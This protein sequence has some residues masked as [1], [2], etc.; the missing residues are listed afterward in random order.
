MLLSNSHCILQSLHKHRFLFLKIKR[1]IFDSISL[2]HLF[3]NAAIVILLE[4]KHHPSICLIHVWFGS[5]LMCFRLHEGI[6]LFLE[7]L[8]PVFANHHL[9]L[10][11]LLLNRLS[12][13]VI[14]WLISFSI[15]LYDVSNV[16]SLIVELISIHV[17]CFF[18]FFSEISL[19]YHFLKLILIDILYKLFSSGC[20][21]NLFHHSLFFL[22]Q[23]YDPCFKINLLLF[24]NFVLINCF[25]HLIWRLELVTSDATWQSFEMSCI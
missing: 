6:L 9:D 20:I 15:C 12:A 8:F 19:I 16:L 14:K 3:L 1:F 21:I 7:M 13:W 24:L 4:R 5:Q 23:F 18:L 10:F 11:T 22:S 25:V 2:H 17:F